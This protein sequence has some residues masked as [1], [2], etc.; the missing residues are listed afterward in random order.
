MVRF[1]AHPILHFGN[2]NPVSAQP[3]RHSFVQEQFL[4][5]APKPRG[6]SAEGRQ[7]LLLG[8]W[9]LKA[10]SS[11]TRGVGPWLAMG[12]MKRCY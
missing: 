10:D 12:E 3:T 6:G 2:K 7:R 5:P 1:Y 4:H 8:L 9:N 11:Q